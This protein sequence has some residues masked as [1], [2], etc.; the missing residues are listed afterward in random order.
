MSENENIPSMQELMGAMPVQIDR[1]VVMIM[2]SMSLRDYFAAIALNG[3]LAGNVKANQKAHI[4]IQK[5]A[6]LMADGM[7]ES[8]IDKGSDDGK[9]NTL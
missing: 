2:P 5:M 1:P 8:R 7:M 6:Y 3:M 9:A 4:S